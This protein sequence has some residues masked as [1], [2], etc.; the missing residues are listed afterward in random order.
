MKF[1]PQRFADV[2][3]YPELKRLHEQ[4]LP[5]VVALMAIHDIGEII[6]IH[7]TGI[8]DHPLSKDA[9]TTIGIPDVPSTVSAARYGVAKELLDY[10][11]T[12]GIRGIT[13]G[14]TKE[15]VPGLRSVWGAPQEKTTEAAKSGDISPTPI[16]VKQETASQGGVQDPDKPE[17][18]KN[19]EEKSDGQASN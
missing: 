10:L 8:F 9:V 3:E 16:G 17:N 2:E 13:L 7:K 6:R 5:H 11:E 4:A 15:D 14:I 19:K 1:T 18:D 12:I